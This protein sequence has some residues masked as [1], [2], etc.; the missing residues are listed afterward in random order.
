[1]SEE[2]PP[3]VWWEISLKVNEEL[4]ESVADAMARFASGGVAISYDSIQPDPD[5]E[6]TPV[7][8][9]TVRAYLPADAE[10]ESRR[11]R[12]EEA[13]WHL[14]RIS[15][16]PDPE[17]REVVEK[18]WSVEWKKNYRP[19]RIG[20]RMRIVPSWMDP[21]PYRHDLVLRLD[22]GMA[23]GTGLHPTTQLCL[24][25][26]EDRVRPG[27]EMIDLGCGS[28][29]LAIAA[30][31]LGAEKALGV[32]IDPQAVRVARE[33]ALLNRVESSVEIRSGSLAGLV[34]D[35]RS[36][37][38]VAANI[39]AIILKEMLAAGLDR[40]VAPG[41]CLV[42]SG[43]LEDQAP[44]VEEVLRAQG[45]RLAE[46]RKRQDWVALVAERPAEKLTAA[47]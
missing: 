46:K 42:L 40:I 11:F 25:T 21:A 27:M 19:V 32:D 6:G 33:N 30:V 10:L 9:L 14:G 23:F 22:P 26:L 31:K 1:V 38:L 47:R 7:G 45:L 3:A 20:R 35:G 44:A 28:G 37:P 15:P 43:I 8:D 24:E 12:L 36:A 18:D 39:L 4:A 29:I 16:L 17:W 41:G 2:R 13:L 34:Q 5:G